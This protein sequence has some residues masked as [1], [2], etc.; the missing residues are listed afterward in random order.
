MPHLQLFTK[1]CI[2]YKIKILPS[3]TSL[4]LSGLPFVCLCETEVDAALSPI[5]IKNNQILVL[6]FP[7][8]INYL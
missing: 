4:P 2:K 1:T 6:D 3:S 5:K 8:Y 7:K